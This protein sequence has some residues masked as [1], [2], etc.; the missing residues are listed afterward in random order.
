MT[1]YRNL[2]QHMEEG[3]CRAERRGHTDMA[4]TYQ[5]AVDRMRLESLPL[6]RSDRSD[7]RAVEIWT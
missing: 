4:E 2:E 3:P 7:E 6:T 1:R 5:A